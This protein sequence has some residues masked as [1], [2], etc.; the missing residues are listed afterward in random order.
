MVIRRIFAVILFIPCI[1]IG[2][3]LTLLSVILTLTATVLSMFSKILLPIASIVTI[4]FI[5]ATY[6]LYKDGV[7][8]NE[9]LLGLVG[10]VVMDVCLL[11]PVFFVEFLPTL[12]GNISAVI[13]R[14]PNLLWG[15][16]EFD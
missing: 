12:F 5:G 1:V 4:F 14:V 13:N 2:L 8:I 11:L 6:F 15:G 9:I 3:I 7:P 10:I 16:G